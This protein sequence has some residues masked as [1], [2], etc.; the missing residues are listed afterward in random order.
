VYAWF[1]SSI[2]AERSSVKAADGKSPGVVQFYNPAKFDPGGAVTEQA[3]TWNAFPKELLK[4]YGPDRA[5]IEADRLLTLDQYSKRLNDPIHFRTLY[6]P[7][8]EYC[9]WHAIRDPDTQ[10]ILKVTFFSEPPEYWRALFGDELAIDGKSTVNS[11]VTVSE[12]LHFT[13]SL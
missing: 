2:G 7:L 10:K 1:E 6:R 12:F 5:L 9:E 3:I 11:R 4:Q 13:A 8:N